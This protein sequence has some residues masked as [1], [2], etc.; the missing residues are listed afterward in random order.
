MTD[1]E[2]LL[3]DEDAAWRELGRCFDR[4][5]ALGRFE[6]PTLTPEGW[7]PK[8]AMFHLAGWMTDCATQLERMRAGAFDPAEETREA[9][10]RQN[11]AWFEASRSMAP[12]DV[13][14]RFEPSRQAMLA[15]FRSL[16]AVT[17][18]AVEW[19]EE[20]GA[21]HYATHAADLWRFLGDEPG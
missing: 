13:R 16:D 9:I 19:F 11:D 14:A 10:E 7:S 4:I 3:E 2:R 18:D 5:V 12:E 17:A 1:V 15:S 8:D 21:L 20:S 6:D